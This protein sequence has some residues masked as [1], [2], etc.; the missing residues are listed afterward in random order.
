MLQLYTLILLFDIWY[1]IILCYG[2]LLS[3]WKKGTLG[4]K[5]KLLDK[6]RHSKMFI[7]LK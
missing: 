6:G 3:S 5:N 4:I 1:I 2:W 7:V